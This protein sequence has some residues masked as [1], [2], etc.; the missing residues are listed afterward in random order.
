MTNRQLFLNH[1]AQTSPAPIAIEM[2]K[3]QGVKMWDADGKEYI[4]LIA[5]FSVANIGHSNPKVIEAVHAQVE[6]YMHLI[7]YGEFIEA[8]QVAYA[9]LFPF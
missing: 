5:G 4:D 3:A 2:V 6:K 8:P 9:K 7:V 1:I